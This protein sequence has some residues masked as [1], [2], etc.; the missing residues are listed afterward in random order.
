M[1]LEK[2]T[3][4]RLRLF[5]EHLLETNRGFNFYIDWDNVAG[6]VRY[7]IELHALDSLIGRKEDFDDVFFALLPR[8]VL[9]LLRAAGASKL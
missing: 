8:L 5:E 9:W 4:E 6:L 2:T 7:A 3:E 1:Y